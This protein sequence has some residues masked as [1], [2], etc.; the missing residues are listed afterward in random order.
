MRTLCK[1][2]RVEREWV[3]A[4][5]FAKRRSAPTPAEYALWQELKGG[6]LGYKFSREIAIGPYFAD[7][8]CRQ[9]RLVIEIDGDSHENKPE[10]DEAKTVALKERGYEVLRFSND[11]VMERTDHVLAAILN[12]LAGRPCWRY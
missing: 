7:F 5:E 11:Q 12:A 3:P 10:A 4:K 2:A 8:C 1:H 9:H 6:K